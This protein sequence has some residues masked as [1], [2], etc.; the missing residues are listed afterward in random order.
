MVYLLWSQLAACRL[1]ICLGGLEAPDAE[2]GTLCTV[3]LSWIQ[4]CRPSSHLESAVRVVGFS[5]GALG[6]GPLPMLM[7]SPCVS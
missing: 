2:W 6:L 1:G 7:G 4:A 3:G 5:C